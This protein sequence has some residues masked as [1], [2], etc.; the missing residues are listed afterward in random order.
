MTKYLKNKKILNIFIKEDIMDN[1]RYSRNV[2]RTYRGAQYIEGNTV[3][4][5]SR[6]EAPRRYEYN[7]RVVRE[8]PGSARKNIKKTTT[9]NAGYVLFVTA[10]LFVV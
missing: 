5:T 10:A 6:Q 3:R 1:R 2:N 9:I 7:G 8:V 4:K